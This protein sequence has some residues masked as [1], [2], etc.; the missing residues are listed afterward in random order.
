MSE[1][2]QAVESVDES[3]AAEAAEP[4]EAVEEAKDAQPLET[5]ESAEAKIVKDTCLAILKDGQLIA[6]TSIKDLRKKLI[7]IPADDLVEVW[8]GRR[9]ELKAK[10]TVT[11]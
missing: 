1:E 6:G 5:I 2:N 8:K 7:H 10:T 4:V 11:F 3:V 9:L